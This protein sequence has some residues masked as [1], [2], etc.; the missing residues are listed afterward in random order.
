VCSRKKHVTGVCDI[1]EERYR[2][3]FTTQRKRAGHK[4]CNDG[5]PATSVRK[6]NFVVKV[7]VLACC[8]ETVCFVPEI[9]DVI[10][11]GQM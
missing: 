1:I 4:A 6:A 7:V 11:P 9:V 8:E 2:I 10:N 3:F 5:I